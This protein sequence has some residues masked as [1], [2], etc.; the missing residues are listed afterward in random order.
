MQ[1]RDLK[2]PFRHTGFV[3]DC[4]NAVL[5]IGVVALA[6]FILMDFRKFLF[7]FPFLFLLATVEQFVLA[8]KYMLRKMTH[9]AALLYIMGIIMAGIT[10]LSMI[11]TF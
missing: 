6:V 7:L 10:V 4:I 3:L 2:R 11:T 8:I 5:C 9:R 1:A